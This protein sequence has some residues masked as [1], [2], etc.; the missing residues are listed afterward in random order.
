MNVV[1]VEKMKVYDWYDG[2][3]PA[4]VRIAI[5]EKNLRARVE[6]VSFRW[7]TSR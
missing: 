1:S 6:F 4:R 2:P 7:R 3:Y 5:A